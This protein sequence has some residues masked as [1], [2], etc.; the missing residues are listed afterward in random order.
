MDLGSAVLSAETAIELAGSQ[1][2]SQVILSDAPLVEGAVA[3]AVEASIGRTLEEVAAA[4]L[5]ARDL[6]K[7]TN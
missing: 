3:A 5:S 6:T 2:R 7:V 1:L 4:A